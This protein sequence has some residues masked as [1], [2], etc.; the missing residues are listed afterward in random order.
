METDRKVVKARGLPWTAT[1]EEVVKFFAPTPVANGEEGVHFTTNRDGRPSGECFVELEGEEELA[2]ALKKDH[3]NMGKRYVEVFEVSVRDMEHAVSGGSPAREPQAYLPAPV[4]EE[5]GVGD[6]GVVRLRGL[7]FEAS[8]GEV[9]EFFAGLEIEENGVLIV[10]DFNGR[11]SGEAFVQFTNTADA[12]SALEKNKAMM[13]RRYIEVFKSS[14]EEAKRAQGMM[15]GCGPGPGGPMRGPGPPGAMRGG[16]GGG[17]MP[18]PYG[19]GP[20]PGPYDRGYGGPPRGG[21]GGPPM[22][23]GGGGPGP[24]RGAR[25]IVHMRGLPFRVT[26]QDIAEWFSSAADPIDVLIHYNHDGRPSGEADCMFASEGDA[27]RALAKNKQNMQHRYVELFYEGPTMP[28]G[29]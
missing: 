8:K 23:Y 26:E 1:A 13:G 20:R 24:M 9:T 5:G 12:A 15:M 7:P 11:A 25:H 29:Y 18:P 10:T 21:Y 22:P 28:G 17:G 6:D 4:A 14:M 2:E 27:T 16:Y 19:G 3:E